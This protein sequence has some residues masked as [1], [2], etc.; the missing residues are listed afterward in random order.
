MKG[1]V[2]IVG[3]IGAA[4]LGVACEST[5]TADG[6]GN[7]E[8]KRRAALQQEQQQRETESEQNLQNAQRDKL[9]RDSNPL[10][11]Y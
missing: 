9:N 3:L 5:Q 8:R 1:A 2:R 4:V 11:G 6:G 7:Q 10:S